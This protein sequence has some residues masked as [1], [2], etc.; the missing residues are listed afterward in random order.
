MA[1]KRVGEILI[2]K[3]FVTDAQLKEALS[4]QEVTHEYLGAILIKKRFIK[5]E[6]LLRALSEQFNIPFVSLKEE[7]IDWELSVKYFS[8]ISFSGKAM[9]IF[10]DEEN[11][12][13]AI[14]DPLDKIS[15][16]TIEQSIRPKKLRLI[17]VL[18]SELKEFIDECKRRS[19]ASFKRLLDEE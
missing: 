9:P 17:L 8:L 3:G 13:V 12:I 1:H 18:E 7:R 16:S 2:E 14:R 5:E 19:H 10:Q 11:V 6:V 15:L 4:T